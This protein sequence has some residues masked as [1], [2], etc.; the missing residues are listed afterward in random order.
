MH[1]LVIHPRRSTRAIWFH[2]E[3]PADR[4]PRFCQFLPSPAHGLML[5]PAG[6]CEQITRP[7][8]V[9]PGLRR[10]QKTVHR[11][12]RSRIREQQSLATFGALQVKHTTV[13]AVGMCVHDV[14]L[15][16]HLCVDPQLFHPDAA[17]AQ[18]LCCEVFRGDVN[19]GVAETIP[20]SVPMQIERCGPRSHT[21]VA[22]DHREIGQQDLGCSQPFSMC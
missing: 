17:V 10:A 12:L 22:V 14:V 19:D 21:R 7:G 6:P 18:T 13:P 2:T 4:D 1:V 5:Q 9:R 20:G 15:R 16:L 3:I 8:F 11:R